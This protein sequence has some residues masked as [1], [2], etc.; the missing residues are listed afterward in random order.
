MEFKIID[1]EAAYRELL[2]TPD[3]ASRERI[4]REALVEPFAGLAQIMGGGDP[5][6]MFERW[7][8]KLD[9]FAP[10]NHDATQVRLDALAAA[11]AF[12]RSVT[13]LERGYAAF[14]EFHPRIRHDS[15]M[16][17]LYLCDLSALPQAG[18]YSGFGAIPGWIMTL[19]DT[20]TERN[21]RCV[22]A[23]TV[24]ELHHNLAAGAD[25]G[26]NF[27]MMTT[28]LGDYMVMEG[29]AESFAAE[30]YG[31]DTIGPWVTD[32]DEPRL[33]DARMLFKS[34]LHVT[35]FDTLRS[36]IF[37]DE[38]IG[39]DKVDVPR[40]AGYALGYKVV[41]AY[42]QRT[43]KSVVQATFTPAEE[44]IAESGFFA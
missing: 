6:T 37:G 33:E 39:G 12:A 8:M 40:Y 16:F 2:A 20:P 11:N 19:Y 13:A 7:N 24:H 3:A 5:M 31:E 27:N 21:L 34:A 17:G 42:L 22:E 30:L 1:T 14:T 26:V 38:I 29:L 18:G 35:G 44:V 36:Y 32:F 23:C 4:F 15:I 10:E 25:S 28:T 9:A 43:G 41:Q